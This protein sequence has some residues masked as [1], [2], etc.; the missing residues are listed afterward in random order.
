MTVNLLH[1]V[2]EVEDCI[3]CELHVDPQRPEAAIDHSAHVG[4][5]ADSVLLDPAAVGVEDDDRP[6]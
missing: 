2:E 4:R 1:L 3:M 5:A 6:A